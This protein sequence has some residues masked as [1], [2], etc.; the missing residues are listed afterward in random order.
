LRN[1][2]LRS[3]SEF[4]FLLINN[5]HESFHS[6]SVCPFWKFVF[7]LVSRDKVFRKGRIS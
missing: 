1:D 2:W 7:G 6:F 5:G 3:Q 4:F